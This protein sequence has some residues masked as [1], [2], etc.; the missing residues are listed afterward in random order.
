ME[1]SVYTKPIK[2]QKLSICLQVFCDETP[3]ALKVYPDVKNNDQ[4]VRFLVKFIEFW[5]IV[6]VRTPYA[7]IVLL[8]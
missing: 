8:Y 6:N 1:V 4:T 5:K 2:G 7:D 3:S